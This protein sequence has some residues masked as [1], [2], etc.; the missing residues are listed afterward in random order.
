MTNKNAFLNV[1]KEE[2]SNKIKD[3]VNIFNQNKNL[4]L[5]ISFRGISYETFIRTSQYFVDLVDEN[6]I[7][8]KNS[9]DIA[10]ILA[11]GNTYRISIL[12][13]EQIDVFISKFSRS[14]ITEIQRHL[15]S[16]NPSE[17]TEIIYKNRGSAN[18]VFINEFCTVIKMTEEVPLRNENDKPK[19]SGSEKILYRY[20][21]RYSFV[22]GKNFRV[23]ISSVQESNNIWNLSRRPY[24]Y[25]IELEII[26][27]KISFDLI[28]NEIESM[29]KIIQDS[30]IP[31]GKTE[32]QNIIHKYQTLLNAKSISHLDSRNVVSLE[33]QH[34]IKFVPNKY[35]ITDK[36]DGERYFLF[37]LEEGLYL[38]STNM[39][40][41]KINLQITDK[42][43][44][45]MI[46][47]GEL[48]HDENNYLFLA[49]DVV[50]AG[51]ID[52]RHNEKFILTDRLN[53]L[54]QIVDK[55]FGNLVPFTNYLD[56]HS[57]VEF[58]LIKKF[59]EVELKNYWKLFNETVAKHQGLFISRKLYFV[60]FGIDPAE[61]FMY[62]DLIW[63]LSVRENLTP[64]SLDGIIYTPISFPYMI[65]VSPEN[66]DS[67]P[68]EYKWKPSY[69]NSIDFYIEFIKDVHG[70]DAIFYDKATMSA[71]ASPYKVC[72]LFVGLH[73]GSQEKPI[74][75]KVDGIEQKANIYVTNG[76]ARDSEERIINDKTVVEFV[77]DMTKPDID[78]AYRWIPLRTRYDK[79]ESVQRY[80]KKYGNNL[81]I[82]T[83][84]W[85]TIVNPITEENIA[86]LG[87]PSTF[88]REL[89]QL[90][91]SMEKG[92]KAGFI[93]YQK[94]T[95]DAAGMR[96]F[97]NWIKTN[98]ISTYCQNKSSVLDIGCGRGG[99]LIKFIHAGVSE[100]VGIDIDDNGLHKISDSAY[101]RYMS[102][103]KK[104]RNVPPMY[105][106]HADARVRFNV[107]AQETAIPKM[108][109]YNK[110]LIET[111]LSGRK[112]YNVINAQFTIH[113]YMSDEISWS[114]FCQNI[115]DNLADNGYVLITGFDGD[116]L[117]QTL[118]SK[119]K[120]TVSYTDN[121][122]VK[123]I[124][125]EIIKIYSDNDPKTGLGMPID[126]YN[127]LISNPGTYIREYLIFPK[128]LEQSL[129]E[130]CG[131][132]LVESDLFYNLFYLYK[133][134][135]MSDN[136][137]GTSN[138]SGTSNILIPNITP[139]KY[140][141]LRNFYLSLHPN[142]HSDIIPDIILASFKLAMLNRYFVFRKTK[143]V[144]VTEPSRIVGINHR[145][146]LGK[147]I[148]PYFNQN[149]IIVDPAMK[150][151]QVNKIYHAI[152][153]Q[154]PNIKPSVYL[155][156]H[157]IP[158]D[159]VGG[160]VYRRNK[161]EFLKVKNGL[162]DTILLIYKSPDKF[163]YPIYHQS[164]HEFMDNWNEDNQNNWI[165][166]SY[167][168]SSHQKTPGSYLLNNSQLI[169]D[170]GLLV[171]LTEKI[172]KK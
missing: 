64:Y 69:L 153:R 108:V 40:V 103:K 86:A 16:L 29:L 59:Y 88:E 142:N 128:F 171:A 114:N 165:D 42:K 26:N 58:D 49:F 131:L 121:L 118:K 84:I 12:D 137:L 68:L 24:N 31:V 111:H 136:M 150:N 147:I 149:H 85:K 56:K 80:Q 57:D 152:R 66:L 140:E 91:K 6:Q 160:Q 120:L 18:R 2:E 169:N 36:A 144:N 44:Y 94:K 76:E 75:F 119:S 100:Y 168:I 139:K 132:E 126:F 79:T 81:N 154:Y 33:I 67:V 167:K 89:E 112:K 74:P 164:E 101:N 125:F 106:I 5:E 170:L 116:L 14:G 53:V 145:I 92:G 23:D 124:F 157:T 35:A 90:A 133:N 123:N 32:T 71:D 155:I 117:Y 51:N 9:L 72:R 113:Y 28:M 77:Y 41:K 135:F 50:Y 7:S 19:L 172:Q 22:T 146:D 87:N 96:A 30:D 27:N 163:F 34:V 10:I 115:N 141:E 158:A 104:L 46:L 63:R 47:D 38:L 21:N 151:A 8:S 138:V 55:C 105:F 93:Y 107:K 134:Y 98:M 148:T 159:Q 130:K 143:N 37:S 109:N 1:L 95:A 20:K 99:D 60:P 4:E 61:V 48:I 127:S 166:L 62:A 78:D 129:K 110:Q 156:R 162:K 102:F 39:N 25:E 11:D 65:K 15:L 122:G 54:N 13:P 70:N 52:Y 45:N 161:F 43:Y 97:N 3:M 83:R 82:A 17:D 73:K